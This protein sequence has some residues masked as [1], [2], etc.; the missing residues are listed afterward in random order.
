MRLDTSL[1]SGY[2]TPT[3]YDSML[4]KLIVW[5][6]D[7][8]GAVAKARRAL[9][10]FYIEG[11]KTNISLHKEIVRDNIFKSG[12]FDTG[13]LDVNMDKFNLDAESSIANEEE[14]TLKL[15]EMIKK[16]KEN[17][18]VSFQNNFTLY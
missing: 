8:D 10:E 6:L 2:E 5:A 18:L 12:K 17:K 4:G 15:A 14:R 1:Y 9:D 13:Y 3:C 7:W 16:I 11:F